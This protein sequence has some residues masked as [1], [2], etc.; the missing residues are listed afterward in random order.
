M[1]F[2]DNEKRELFKSEVGKYVP[3]PPSLR[4]YNN[5]IQ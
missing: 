5:I 1:R 3:L 2:L 4:N